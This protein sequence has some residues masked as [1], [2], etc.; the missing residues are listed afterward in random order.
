LAY[1]TLGAI[2]GL[3]GAALDLGGAMT[4]L[5]HLAAVSAGVMMIAVG[6]V[7][8]LRWSGVRFP[9]L[10]GSGKLHRAVALAQRS[11]LK[12]GPT[13]RAGTIGLLSALLPCGWLYAFAIVAGG[14]ASAVWGA[15]IM[16]AFWIG[17]VPIL[18]T[19][20]V[21]VQALTG[22]VGRRIPVVMALLLV[23]LGLFTIADRLAIPVQ[24]F[25]APLQV[26]TESDVREQVEAL[27]Q[28]EPA[29]CQHHDD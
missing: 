12:L 25:Q 21:G 17:T 16:T 11:A 28:S 5:H 13:S 24:A 29:C 20:G 26:D 27:Q 18:A 2:C 6:V 7:V 1:A 15:A 9:Q 23:L 22:T 10:P 3:L 19:V 8:V 4:G 14:T